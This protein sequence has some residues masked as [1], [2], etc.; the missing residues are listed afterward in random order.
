MPNL[1]GIS[2]GNKVNLVVEKLGGGVKKYST[3][4]FDLIRVRMGRG[5][6]QVSHGERVLLNAVKLAEGETQHVASVSGD[7]GKE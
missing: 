2:F 7:S 1:C 4:P 3:V 5:A 6:I